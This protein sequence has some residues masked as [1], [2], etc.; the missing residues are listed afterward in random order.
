LESFQ[1]VITLQS[2][3]RQ[4]AAI[5]CKTWRN[6][7]KAKNNSKVITSQNISTQC[8]TLHVCAR[9]SIAQQEFLKFNAYRTARPDWLMVHES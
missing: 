8:P 3:T 9:Q 6:R 7:T 2:T 5:H 4:N 1:K